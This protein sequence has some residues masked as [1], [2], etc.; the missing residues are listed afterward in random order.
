MV[1]IVLCDNRRL[2]RNAS[3][4][5]NY[6]QEA[7]IMPAYAH[8]PMTTY[9]AQN[10]AGIIRQCLV[11]EHRWVLFFRSSYRF[12]AYWTLRRKQENLRMSKILYLQSFEIVLI[13]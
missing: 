11:T 6:Q 5:Y 12:K 4:T 3:I 9:Y 10:Y 8:V 13:Y 1:P 7:S 2:K